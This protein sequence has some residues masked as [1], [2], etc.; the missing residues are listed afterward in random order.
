MV[1]VADKTALGDGL[2]T[3]VVAAATVKLC[4][5]SAA[6]TSDAHKEVLADTHVPS[7][8]PATV[9]LGGKRCCQLG[10]SFLPSLGEHAAAKKVSGGFWLFIMTGFDLLFELSDKLDGLP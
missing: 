6:S 1:A 2:S 8:L 4:P 10:P 3:P 9:S 5:P 7:K